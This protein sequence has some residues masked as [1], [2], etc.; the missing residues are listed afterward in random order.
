MNIINKILSIFKNI[1]DVSYKEFIKN[2]N[3]EDISYYSFHKPIII[4][5]HSERCIVSKTVMKDFIKFYKNNPDKFAYIVVDVIDNR[6]LSNKIADKFNVIHQ[7][8]QLLIIKN[9][10]CAFYESH[11]NI[12]FNDV[13]NI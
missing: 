11:N 6:I 10:V 5:K 7:S 13:E 1:N 2:Y 3:I 12:N 8:P 9:D 4:L